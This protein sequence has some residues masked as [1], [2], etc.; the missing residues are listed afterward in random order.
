MIDKL[1]FRKKNI[2][3]KDL[4]LLQ[5][6]SKLRMHH[7]NG[8]VYYDN[9]DTKDFNGGFYIHIDTKG[10]LKV[11]GS[12]HKFYNFLNGGKLDNY[13]NITMQESRETILKILEFYGLGSVGGYLISSFEVG[14]NFETERPTHWILKKLDNIGNKPFYFNPMYKDESHKTTEINKDFKRIF[15]VYDKLHELKDKKRKPPPNINH[16]TRCE[17]IYRRCERLELETFLN[18]EFLKEKERIFWQEMKSIKL[19]K[20][21]EYTGVGVCSHSK[22]QTAKDILQFGTVRAL[23]LAK[24][25]HEKKELT[26]KQYRT[27]REFIR[28]WH[29]KEYYKNFKLNE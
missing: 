7:K 8:A 15:R 16:L 27:V 21:V 24:E 14:A 19:K 10:T 11:G 3:E 1:T 23:E 2:S 12:V 4:K 26:P 18:I 28:D 13:N 9:K 29:D 6:K 5:K 22:K 20:F 17:S 25:R